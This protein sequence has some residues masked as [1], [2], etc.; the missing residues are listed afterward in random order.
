MW[1]LR[2]ARLMGNVQKQNAKQGV[3]GVGLALIGGLNKPEAYADRINREF[4]LR[5]YA[6]TWD[7]YDSNHAY[8]K[9]LYGDDPVTSINH[10]ASPPKSLL[11]RQPGAIASG[12]NLL[13]PVAPGASA[14]GPFGTDGQFATGSATSSR[15]LYET[16]SLVPPSI[17]LMP[18][19]VTDHNRL[20]RRLGVRIGERRG[21][22]VF[23]VG[24]PAVPFA[25][26]DPFPL[27]G[28]PA[29]LDQ[30]FEASSS[31]APNGPSSDDLERFRRQW[32]KTF[33]E[34]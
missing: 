29:T 2:L 18:P 23:D 33:T 16:Q 13:S 19:D 24:A 10:P 4:N 1:Q 17:G 6:K 9:E 28:R 27:A 32:L 5:N 31:L 25:S 15:P 34:P 12:Y 20:E 7:I 22:T 30:R 3:R 11:P 14:F 8:W 26:S 21:S